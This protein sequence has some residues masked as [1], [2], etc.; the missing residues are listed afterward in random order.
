MKIYIGEIFVSVPTIIIE[1]KAHVARNSTEYVR[2]SRCCERPCEHLFERKMFWA[3][4]DNSTE[5]NTL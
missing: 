2:S 3:C 5:I 1:T 4:R